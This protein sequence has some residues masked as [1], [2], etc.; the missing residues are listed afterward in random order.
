METRSIVTLSCRVSPQHYF[1]LLLRTWLRGNWAWFVLLFALLVGLSIHNPLFIYVGLILIFLVFPLILYY[2]WFAYAL[3]PDCR[4]SILSK[5]VELN[6][7]GI[8][9]KFDDGREEFIPWE[10][11]SHI[12]YSSTDIIFHLSKYIFFILP[13]DAF[14]SI[15]DLEYFLKKIPHPNLRN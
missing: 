4:A 5:S 1:G 2:L 12:S 13:C 15:D 8:L 10:R 14:H 7:E 11:I 3:H 9:C 6:H